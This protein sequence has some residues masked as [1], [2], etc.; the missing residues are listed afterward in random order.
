ME[1]VRS[2]EVCHRL[3]IAPKRREDLAKLVSIRS[4]S[5]FMYISVATGVVYLCSYMCS[6]SL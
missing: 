3:V 1:H 6:I 5:N 2:L 4:Q